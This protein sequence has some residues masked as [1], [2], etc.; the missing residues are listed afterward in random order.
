MPLPQLLLSHREPLSRN[1]KAPVSPHPLC[2]LRVSAFHFAFSVNC[3][4]T[5]AN[6]RTTPRTVHFFALSLFLSIVFTPY[7]KIR[8]RGVPLALAFMPA[9][10]LYFHKEPQNEFA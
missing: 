7:N 5:T 9:P 4:L 10:L 2:A 6:L 8:G 1:S 3:R